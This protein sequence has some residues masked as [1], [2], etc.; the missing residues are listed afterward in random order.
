MVHATLCIWAVAAS[1]GTPTE[2][3]LVSPTS[4]IVAPLQLQLAVGD[5]AQVRVVLL[6]GKDTVRIDARKDGS[7]MRCY[8]V[9]CE[10]QFGSEWDGQSSRIV[11]TTYTATVEIDW[12]VGLAPGS[13]T[14]EF[15]F[16]KSGPCPDPPECFLTGWVDLLPAQSVA[17]TVQ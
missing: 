9:L 12:V 11:K 8:S 1:C 3:A 7:I 17:I 16:G 4:M 15:L 14:L 10:P 5:T 2:P 6:Q 13:E